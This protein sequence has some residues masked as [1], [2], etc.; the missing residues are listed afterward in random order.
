MVKITKHEIYEAYRK[1]K[2]YYYDNT[3][4]TSRYKIAEF[5]RKFYVEP[6]SDFEQ[7]FE[8]AMDGVYKIVNG[9]DKADRLLN[10]LLSEIKFTYI[11]KSVEKSDEKN[12]NKQLIRDED[13]RQEHSRNLLRESERRKVVNM[14]SPAWASYYS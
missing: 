6:H 8:T 11:T 3:S 4:L 1:L 2:N 13:R 5:E 9:E 14:T 10:S 12:Q 7:R